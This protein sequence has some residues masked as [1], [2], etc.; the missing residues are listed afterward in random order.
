M[1]DL[2][3]YDATCQQGSDRPRRA[4]EQWSRL[5]WN[6]GEPST[7]E[8]V[9]WNAPAS[10]VITWQTRNISGIL[11]KEGTAEIAHRDGTAPGDRPHRHSPSTWSIHGAIWHA[12][13][14]ADDSS[15]PTSQA[16]NATITL[17]AAA[18]DCDAQFKWQRNGADIQWHQQQLHIPSLNWGQ[19]GAVPRDR[20][21]SARQQQ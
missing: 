19:W 9:L 18:T 2:L 7:C 12:D 10:T 8:G 15:R 20:Y 14:C 3:Q 13:S 6:S 5:A 17:A 21:N 1:L 16:E 11:H 4:M